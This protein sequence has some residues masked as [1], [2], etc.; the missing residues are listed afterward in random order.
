MIERVFL[1][2][3]AYVLFMIFLGKFASFAAGFN[4]E[5]STGDSLSEEELAARYGLHDLV[6]KQ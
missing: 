2:I 4:A 1:G 6:L 5:E 3:A